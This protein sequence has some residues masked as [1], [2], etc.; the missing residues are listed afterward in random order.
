MD[1]FSF[2]NMMSG[3]EAM[4]SN[5]RRTAILAIGSIALAMLIV[6]W[7]VN[8]Q[9]DLIILLFI[10]LA[11][12]LPFIVQLVKSSKPNK[13][14][15][16][17]TEVHFSGEQVEIVHHG[18]DRFD[19]RKAH[20]EALV[21]APET[22]RS[23]GYDERKRR[24]EI[25]HKRPGKPLGIE[26]WHPKEEV[27]S[28]LLARFAGY[29]KMN[30][31]GSQADPEKLAGSSR[32]EGARAETARRRR[33]DLAN[34]SIIPLRKDPKMEGKASSR[35]DL[36]PFAAALVLPIPIGYV[37]NIVLLGTSFEGPFVFVFVCWIMY[38]IPVF[39]ISYLALRSSRTAV[40]DREVEI[41]GDGLLV[42]TGRK[43][44][45][46][47][48]CNES[49]SRPP[50]VERIEGCKVGKRWIEVRG[51]FRKVEVGATDMWPIGWGDVVRSFKVARIYS[52]ED[53]K[54]LLDWLSELEGR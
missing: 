26:R 53:E 32:L 4:L 18:I 13:M 41:H 44:R 40:H 35:Q 30:L 14:A 42:T 28:A 23:I 8:L 21:L 11:F 5:M 16:F 25:V 15:G 49:D 36:L 43:G 29:S 12:L 27:L 10:E 37:L 22:I 9:S 24:L 47:C 6:I 38:S 17:R 48:I 54:L 2:F 45:L 52:D 50:L 51:D 19:G 1:D 46:H 33:R 7:A 3:F 20:D 31:D 39:I 34:G